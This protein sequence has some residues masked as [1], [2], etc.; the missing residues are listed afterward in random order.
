MKRLLSAKASA[1]LALAGLVGSGLIE[2]R[3]DSNLW[4]PSEERPVK[5]EYSGKDKDLKKIAAIVARHAPDDHFHTIRLSLKKN[6]RTAAE[7][8][9]IVADSI[10][11][12]VT[13][14]APSKKGLTYG[15]LSLYRPNSI[16]DREDSPKNALRILN[17]WDNMDGTIER[18]YAGKSIW[19]WDGLLS[20]KDKETYEKYALA[21]AMAGIN[22]TVVN[23]VNAS[24]KMLTRPVLE[25]LAEISDILRPYG[26]KT[27]LSVNFASPMALGDLKTADPLDE[28]VAKWW[29]DKADEIYSLIPDFGGFLVKAN[30][31]GQPGPCDFGRLHADGAN[32]LARALQDKGGIVMWRAFVYSPSD[33]DRAKQ[34]YAEFQPL[35][36]KFAPNVMVQVK[37]GPVDFQPREPYSPLFDGMMET[38][39]IAEL[40]VTQE[41]LGHSN[42]LA[43]LAPMWEEFFEEAGTDRIKGVAGVANIGDADNM[44]GHPLAQANWYAFGRMAWDPSLM[45]D[46]IAR[47]WAGITPWINAEG[48]QLDA[49][50]AMMTGSREH[51]VDY[52]MPMGLHHLFAF[53]HHYGPEPWCEVEGARQDWLPEYYHN[54]DREGI[55]FDRT[56][57]TGSGAT[58]QYRLEIGNKL[59]NASTCPEKYLLWFHKLPWNYKLTWGETLWDALNR[60]YDAGVEG[61]ADMRRTWAALDGSVDEDI[62]EDV[63]DRLL[64]QHKDGI[65]W[66]DACLEYFGERAGLKPIN[67]SLHR[68]SDLKKVK[69]GID[70]YTCPDSDLLDSVR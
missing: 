30:S 28:S 53:G 27:Y 64:T 9:R 12:I 41:Y 24:P 38:P 11:R 36:G 26:I 23:N 51:V 48:E 52:M 35:D 43:Y 37:N 5:V 45:S 39:L 22:G 46:D 25:R 56:Q 15:V 1:M 47:E 58:A 70:N 44:T 54:A 34:A 10:Q 2:A 14:T 50:T 55:G 29:K 65:W 59:E 31:E 4:L 6:D 40:Q 63:S 57:S 8:Y 67:P 61:V 19:K 16:A 62:H 7:S 32:M 60:H 49:F 42:H 69:L 13:V 33:P 66:R 21:N 68:L 3:R 20:E 17:H 18:G